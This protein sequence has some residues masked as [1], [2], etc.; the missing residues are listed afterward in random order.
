MAGISSDIIRGYN[1]PM[2]LY[3]LLAPPP[4]CLT[5]IFPLEFLPE[6]FLRLV[7]SDFSGVFSKKNGL[8][9][10]ETCDADGIRSRA[11]AQQGIPKTRD[12]ERAGEGG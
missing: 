1:D 7:V 4:L 8:R 9:G 5:V 6:C 3:L 10:K 12:T 11:A 2:I